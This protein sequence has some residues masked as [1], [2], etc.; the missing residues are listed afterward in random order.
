MRLELLRFFTVQ[1]PEGVEVELLFE[2][3]VSVHG[4][5]AL[6]KNP[7]AARIPHSGEASALSS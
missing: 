2:L 7:T 3:W 1:R 5:K 6:F 4:F